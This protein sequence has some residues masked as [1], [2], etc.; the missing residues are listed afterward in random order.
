ME[1]TIN[2]N[3][4]VPPVMD[5]HMD[6]SLDCNCEIFYTTTPQNK[7]Q[8]FYAIAFYG[9]RKNDTWHYSFSTEEK[10][11]NYINKYIEDC[12][13]LWN[14]KKKE[15]LKQNKHKKVL[16]LKLV[17]CSIIALDMI[18]QIVNFTK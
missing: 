18:K 17:I 15:K 13:E 5:A 6:M 7:C 2:T 16:M 3:R 10:M 1:S 8:K 12:I 9:K 11:M 4:Y 14:H